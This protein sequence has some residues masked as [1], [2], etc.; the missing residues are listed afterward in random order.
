MKFETCKTAADVKIEGHNI[1]LDKTGDTLNGVSI[2]KDGAV[3]ARIVLRSYSMSI[4]RPVAPP[5]V[6]KHRLTGTVLG[7]AVDQVYDD[8]YQAERARDEFFSNVMSGAELSVETV[9]V[10]ADDGIFA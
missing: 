6:T 7:L 9:L 1:E 5:K 3:V 10:D 4:E 8:E 2:I